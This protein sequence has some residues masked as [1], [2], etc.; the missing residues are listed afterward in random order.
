MPTPG[1]NCFQRQSV[2]L[3]LKS[4]WAIYESRIRQVLGGLRVAYACGTPRQIKD[5][6]S[7]EVLCDPDIQLWSRLLV[8]P[9][10]NQ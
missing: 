8:S 10:L 5:C 9:S 6:M 2:L 3:E 7:I 1:K 4:C